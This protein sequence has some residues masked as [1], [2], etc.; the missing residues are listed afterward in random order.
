METSRLIGGDGAA[1]LERRIKKFTKHAFARYQSVYILIGLR[2]GV[3]ARTR[4]VCIYR[5]LRL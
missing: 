2:V 1:A 3:S 5:E 4:R